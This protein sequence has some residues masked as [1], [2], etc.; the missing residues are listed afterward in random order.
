MLLPTADRRR[1][2]DVVPSLEA[3]ALLIVLSLVL[4]LTAAFDL[5]PIAV[6][7]QTLVELVILDLLVRLVPRLVPAGSGA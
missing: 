1:R 3:F 7:T 4:A 2:I 6:V 5:A